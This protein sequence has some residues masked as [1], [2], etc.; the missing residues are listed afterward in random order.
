[1]QREELGTTQTRCK[2]DFCHYCVTLVFPQTLNASGNA[3]AQTLEMRIHF[4]VILPETETWAQTLGTLAQVHVAQAELC[5][6]QMQSR[7]HSL[8]THTNTPR[9]LGTREPSGPRDSSTEVWAGEDTKLFSDSLHPF[10]WLV[11]RILRGY[12]SA[13]KAL[14]R[15]PV[16]SCDPAPAACW[17]EAPMRLVLG[18]PRALSPLCDSKYRKRAKS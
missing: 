11:T 13:G 8:N 3:A 5:H 14:Q 6:V 2:S 12:W 4:E 17:M 7:A 10:T 1:M 15:L 16:P 9:A 18:W